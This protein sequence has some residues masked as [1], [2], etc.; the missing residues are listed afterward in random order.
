MLHVDEGVWGE[1]RG[2]DRDKDRERERERQTE[3]DGGGGYA[4]YILLY[5]CS[6]ILIAIHNS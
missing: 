1:G 3:R 5:F 4:S 2:R 6:Y